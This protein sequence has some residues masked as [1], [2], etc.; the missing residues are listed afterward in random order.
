MDSIQAT[1]EFR[2]YGEVEKYCFQAFDSVIH[3]TVE[4]NRNT[5]WGPIALLSQ[6]SYL[7]PEFREVY[8]S[9]SDSIKNSFHGQLVA[10][11]LY[12]VGR[13]GDRMPE[14]TAT[15][16][17]GKE[18]SLSSLCKDRKCVLLDFW[19]SWCGPCRREIPNLKEIYKRHAGDGFE[20]VS[21]SIDTDDA[22][23]KKAVDEEKLS[24]T[25]IRDTDKSIADLY[26]VTSVPTMYIVDSN[27]C[28]V[29][30]NL[31]GEELATRID[32][33]LADD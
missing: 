4:Q 17:D 10:Q 30:E 11:E 2:A 31:R 32:E 14:F 9:F 33:I 23:W 26:K 6:L 20:I 27:G 22:P 19:A 1:E 12:P 28:L 13:P 16:I 5:I 8:E 24:W 18:I 21:V 15:S 25:N 3:A 7:S 29:A